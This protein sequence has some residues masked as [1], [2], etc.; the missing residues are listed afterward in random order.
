MGNIIGT[1]N[2]K[3][4]P[5]VSGTNTAGGVGV[6]GASDT[7]QGVL[8]ESTNQAGVVG[9][10]TNFVGVWGESK[11]ANQ[12]GVF[13]LSE[14]WQGVH[15]ESTDQAG[16]YGVSQDFVGVWGESKSVGQ[17]GVFGL[18]EKWQGVHGES[19]DQ[20]GVYGVSQDFVGVWGESKS[21]G[22]PGVF[23]LSEKWQGVHGESTDQVGVLGMSQNFV[24][25]WGE[26]RNPKQPGIFG[27][28]ALAARFEGDVE[29]TGDIRLVNADVAEDFS[30]EDVSIDPGTVMVFNKGGLLSACMLEYDKKVAGVVSG[31]GSYKPG[32]VL[33]THNAAGN[34]LPV[35]LLGKVFC[36]VDADLN[37]I[38][39]GDLLTTSAT[40]GHAMKAAKLSRS[41]GTVIGKA[42]Q[43]LLSG[44]GL[45]P[46]LI[47]LQ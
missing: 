30:V 19:T 34:R 12:P 32:L 8:G 1:S 24:G 5:A 15:G 22:Q 33:D 10:S 6:S 42:L 46:V 17:P 13:G 44:K 27:K 11:S 3:N 47:S 36:K 45:I 20:A 28:G 21:V 41:F 26:S 2:D 14:K 18:S 9:I 4:T 35:A 39:I 25:V 40:P 43:P 37:A 31:A 29:I 7:W 16:V 23:G 38:E